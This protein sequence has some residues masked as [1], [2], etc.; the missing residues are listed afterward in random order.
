[1]QRYGQ[2]NDAES[3]A[4]VAAG[5]RNSVDRFRPEF[6]GY[7]LELRFR[8]TSQILRRFDRI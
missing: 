6:S 7:I 4:K 1:V 2:L 3:G 8:N 5:D